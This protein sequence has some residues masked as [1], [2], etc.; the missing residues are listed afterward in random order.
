MGTRNLICVVKDGK[1]KLT[2]YCQWDGYLDGQGADIVKFIIKTNQENSWL[3]FSDHLDALVYLSDNEIEARL[4]E[5]GSKGSAMVSVDVSAAFLKKY[6]QLH[7]DMGAD[8][9]YKIMDQA[10]LEVDGID[11]S[12]TKESWCE[13]C[14]VLDLDNKVLE[15]Y[16][17]K[18]GQFL[19]RFGS[20]IV[21]LCK[22]LFSKIDSN[23]IAQIKKDHT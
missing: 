21:L 3:R 11:T 14:Y 12:F 7:R 1:F 4:E 23:T 8:I 19:G 2:K 13:Y 9:L 18:Y 15:I 5:C 16:S 10:N 20:D 6:P 22:V 17:R